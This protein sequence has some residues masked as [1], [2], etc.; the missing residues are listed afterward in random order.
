MG[1]KAVRGGMGS[2]PVA[3]GE[4]HQTRCPV[5][6][7]TRRAPG[8]LAVLPPAAVMRADARISTPGAGMGPPIVHSCRRPL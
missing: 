7:T 6:R 3:A 1:K 8:G 5:T 2:A 4:W